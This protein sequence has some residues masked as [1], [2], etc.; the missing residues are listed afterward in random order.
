[1]KKVPTP[2]ERPDLYDDYDCQPPTNPASEAY[3]DSVR[4]DD[5]RKELEQIRAKKASADSG[6]ATDAG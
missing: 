5:V 3:W 2:E 1:M 4:P 6:D